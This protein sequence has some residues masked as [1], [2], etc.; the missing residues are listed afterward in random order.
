[1]RILVATFALLVLPGCWIFQDYP[2]DD[3]WSDWGTD[4][5]WDT[6][7]VDAVDVSLARSGTLESFAVRA[8]GLGLTSRGEVW[9]GMNE[10][11]C[12]VEPRSMSI[13][14][15]Y[16]LDTSSTEHVEEVTGHGDLVVTT[17]HTVHVVR[18]SGGTWQDVT[19]IGLVTAAAHG[20]GLVV[21]QRTGGECAVGWIADGPTVRVPVDPGACTTG[22]IA[23]T[24]TGTVAVATGDDTLVVT[25]EGST[26]TGVAGELVAWDEVAQVFYVGARDARELHALEPEGGA[27]WTAELPGRLVALTVDR[28][29]GAALVAVRANR[30]GELLRLD[31]WTGAITT[32]GTTSRPPESIVTSPAGTRLGLVFDDQVAF[33]TWGQ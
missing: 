13:T 8:Q 1:M 20:D 19:V 27:R 6:D 24:P 7:T 25:P 9:L 3:L 12:A 23:V 15:D 18:P 26:P 5:S 4:W 32:V 10:A 21:V 22:A 30:Q 33:V 2:E 28:P 29:G 11:L 14:Q 31:G 17:D 16:Q